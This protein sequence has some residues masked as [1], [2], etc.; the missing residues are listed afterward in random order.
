MGNVLTKSFS[1]TNQNDI[2]NYLKFNYIHFRNLRL[3]AKKVV[4]VELY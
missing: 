3:H 1:L 4:R 2:H